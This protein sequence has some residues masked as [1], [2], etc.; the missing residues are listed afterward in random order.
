MFAPEA[1]QKKVHLD[2]RTSEIMKERFNN[3]YTGIVKRKV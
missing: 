2:R 1:Y 3:R